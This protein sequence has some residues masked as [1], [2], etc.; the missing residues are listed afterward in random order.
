MQQPASEL[1]IREA[2]AAIMSSTFVVL[3]PLGAMLVYLPTGSKAIPYLDA[4]F[5]I[6]TTYVAIAGLVLVVLLCSPD[7][8]RGYYPIIGCVI[9]GLIVLVQPS[10]GCRPLQRP[11]GRVMAFSYAGFVIWPSSKTDTMDPVETKER[12][13]YDSQRSINSHHCT[14]FSNDG[15]SNNLR[16][17]G[18][19]NAHIPTSSH[20]ANGYNNTSG[21]RAPVYDRMTG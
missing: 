11:C 6:F 3:L 9:V 2:H 16:R 4:P 12:S 20:V 10:L 7:E 13:N 8:Y 19:T 18:F 15:H 5:Q 1:H 14:G 17:Q 21:R